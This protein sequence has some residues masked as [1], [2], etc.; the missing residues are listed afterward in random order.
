MTAKWLEPG[1][2]NQWPIGGEGQPESSASWAP[3]S[4]Y[5]QAPARLGLPRESPTQTQ[6]CTSRPRPHRRQPFTTSWTWASPQA[7]VPG[8]R[9]AGS[10]STTAPPPNP[11]PPVGGQS[12]LWNAWGHR[13]PPAVNGGERG[14]QALLGSGGRGAQS[15]CPPGEG[16]APPYSKSRS[17]GPTPHTL[18]KTDHPRGPDQERD[19]RL[20]KYSTRSKKTS[21]SLGLRGQSCLPSAGLCSRRQDGAEWGEWDFAQWLSGP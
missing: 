17:H 19:R 20:K 8:S 16:V 14:G 15:L 18:S 21:Y 5:G 1:P 13:K 4:V 3:Q 7:P 11:R 6:G 12:R 10:W 2:N 9:Q